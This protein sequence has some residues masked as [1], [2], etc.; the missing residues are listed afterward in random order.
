MTA[1]TASLIPRH[2]AVI[3]DGNGRWAGQRGLPRLKGHEAGAE[4]VQA[5]MKASRNAGV[6]IVTL[7]TFS[8]ENW[9]RPEDEVSGLMN[10][11]PRMLTK[12]ENLLHENE[13]RLRAIGR[14][15]QLPPKTLKELKRVMEATAHHTTRQVVLALN[16]GGRAELSDAMRKIAVKVKEGEL[17]PTVITE[18]V[19]AG[20]LYA[21]DLPDPDLMIRTSGENRLSNF[22]LWQLSYAEFY[23]AS[24]LWPD[25]R[26][27]A[28]NRAL[29][30]YAHRKRRF[31]GVESC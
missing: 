7:Y 28:F 3:M 8:V 21:P 29:E 31:G 5:V 27:E 19:I 1:E 26:E 9:K 4:S 20:H 11:L 10:L 25:F 23:F 6:E 24:E 13:T 18:E 14:L 2:V 12:H 17:E 22:L 30:E 15:D 16:Y